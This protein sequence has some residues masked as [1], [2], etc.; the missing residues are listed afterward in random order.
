MSHR[1]SEGAKVRVFLLSDQ[2]LF[3]QGVEN[4]LRRET[5]LEIVGCEADI[6]QALECV[7]ELL[8]DVVIVNDADV[9]CD[10]TS[11]AWRILKEGVVP[12]IIGLNLQDNMMC[13]YRGEQREVKKVEDLV[14]AIEQL[15]AV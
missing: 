13:I 7:K 9:S 14:R 4:L 10:P 12:K 11:A 3:R 1:Q 5:G 15:S 6:G 2:S 8:P